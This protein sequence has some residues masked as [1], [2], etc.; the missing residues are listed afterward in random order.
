MAAHLVSGPSRGYPTRRRWTRTHRRSDTPT[1]SPGPDRGSF[2]RVTSRGYL[3]PY[4]CQFVD[5]G[6]TV[7]FD[8]GLE[9]SL[10]N[11]FRYE[12]LPGGS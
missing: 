2:G 10:S 5:G 6:F 12:G 7:R 4:I 8:K 1:V 3:V 9:V 11:K